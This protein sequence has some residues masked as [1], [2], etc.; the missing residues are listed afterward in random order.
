MTLDPTYPFFP[1]IGFISCALVLVPLPW[2]IR[3][4]NTGTTMFMLWSSL[5]TFCQALNA[6]LW[7][8]DYDL[9]YLGWCDFSMSVFT[10]IT[11]QI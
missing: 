4:M 3:A 11:V 9:K 10:R 1:V 2:H 6:V 5:Y 8:D 7:R